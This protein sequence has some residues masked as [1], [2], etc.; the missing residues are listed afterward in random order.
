MCGLI[1]MP[2]IAPLDTDETEIGHVERAGFLGDTA[3]FA[4]VEG[5]IHMLSDRHHELPVHDGLLAA[6]FSIDGYLL[7][8]GGEDGKVCSVSSNGDVQT[9]AEEKGWWI[10]KIASGP[11]GAI[12]YGAGK[13]GVVLNA[14][15]EKKPF[16]CERSIEGMAFAPKGMRLAIARYNGVD[17]NWVNTNN[18][19]QFLE[20]AGAHTDVIFSP[21]G[22]YVVSAM[23][24]NALHGWRIVDNKHMRMS[25]YPAKVKS[26]S[27]S[28][29]GKWLA[30]SGAPAAIVWPFSGK[31]G[32]MG[33]AP[34][35]LGAMGGGLMVTYVTCHPEEEVVAIGY[36]DGMVLAVRIEDGKEAMLKRAGKSPISSLGWDKDGKRIAYGSEAGEAGIIDLKG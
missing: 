36:S 4:S 27:F 28:A 35:E 1:R 33:K 31:D 18:P 14:N 32:P 3:V 29:K 10:D 34:K 23:Q 13:K 5:S 25:G 8:T 11:S 20:W 9:L 30:S 7:I 19:P 15:G 12:A 16:T 22:K 2:S 26:L 24:E 6:K 21:D 17:L